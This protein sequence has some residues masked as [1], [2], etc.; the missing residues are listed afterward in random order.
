MLNHRALTV[1]VLLVAALPGCATQTAAFSD[2]DKSGIRTTVEEFMA[3]INRGDH[4]AAAA[5]YAE[6]GVIMPPN[7][8]AVEGRAGIQKVLEGLGR[9]QAFSQSIVEIEGE[10]NLAYAHLD[11]DL[12]MTP[13]NATAPVNDRGKGLIVMRKEADGRWRTIRG[14]HNSS[15]PASR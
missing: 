4:A 6:N 9:P 3:A 15:L 12:T 1:A 10:G 11:F 14:M 2:S 7:G 5:L 8:P 13:P